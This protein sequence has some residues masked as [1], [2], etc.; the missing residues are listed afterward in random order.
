MSQPTQV[1]ELQNKLPE[2][3]AY[4]FLDVRFSKAGKHFLLP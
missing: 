4:L 1:A 2:S 3:P